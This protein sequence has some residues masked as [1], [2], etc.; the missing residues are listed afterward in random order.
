M[1]VLK[2]VSFQLCSVYVYIPPLRSTGGHSTQFDTN[3]YTLPDSSTS[4]E[5]LHSVSSACCSSTVAAAGGGTGG[6]SSR[7]IVVNRAEGGGYLSEG[8][9]MLMS[10]GGAHN[11][12]ATSATA[13]AND[14]S[15]PV[16]CGYTSE[17]GLSSYAR[18]M[19]ARFREGIEAAV[20][21]GMLRHRQQH[22]YNDSRK[23]ELNENGLGYWAVRFEVV[24]KC[25]VFYIVEN[26][27]LYE[28]V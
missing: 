27:E 4:E 25:D 1:M 28:M 13:N 22:D 6:I 7:H 17:G 26:V 10:A 5:S 19:Q 15:V 3:R 9:S 20:R 23:L 11:S 24:T 16:R 18:K 21:D 12:S 8:D 2:C 14:I